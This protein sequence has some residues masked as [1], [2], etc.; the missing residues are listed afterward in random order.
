MSGTIEQNITFL[1]GRGSSVNFSVCCESERRSAFVLIDFPRTAIEGDSCSRLS[2]APQYFA[3][4]TP[5]CAPKRSLVCWRGAPAP[6][7]AVDAQGD[8]GRPSPRPGSLRVPCLAAGSRVLRAACAR[9]RPDRASLVIQW[10]SQP[11][12]LGLPMLLG[13]RC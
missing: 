5:G 2:T 7:H 8:R 12:E 11:M 13:R 10:V 9:L 4:S 3:Y 1:R 6:A